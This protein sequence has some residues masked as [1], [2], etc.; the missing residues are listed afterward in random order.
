[1]NKSASFLLQFREEELLSLLFIF[2][3]ADILGQHP[4]QAVVVKGTQVF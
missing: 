3:P 4:G 2:R 1:L